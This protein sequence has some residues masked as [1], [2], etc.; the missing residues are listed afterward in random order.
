MQNYNTCVK[1]AIFIGGPGGTFKFNKVDSI[2]QGL[3]S[4]FG[5][6]P[7]L[8]PWMIH[9]GTVMTYMGTAMTHTGTAMIHMGTSM[10]HMGTVMTHTGTAMIHMSTAMTHTGTAMTHM[11]TVGAERRLNHWDRAA[12]FWS[13]GNVT[14]ST[15]S[16]YKVGWLVGW[17]GFNGTFSTNR[18]Y[19]AIGK[20]KLC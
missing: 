19:R 13:P 16:D 7:V 17:L 14:K 2:A 12:P 1:T 6:M 8:P 3:G 10:T 5:R 15:C 11:G 18:P 9:M 4:Y 20:V